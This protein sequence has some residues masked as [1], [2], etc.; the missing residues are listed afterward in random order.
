[1]KIFVSCRRWSSN[2]WWNRELTLQCKLKCYLNPW[3]T[4]WA[5]ALVK[6]IREPHEVKKKSF[7]LGG[8]RTERERTERESNRGRVTVDL[9]RRSWVRFPPRSKDFFF[10]SCGSLTPF[11][12]ANAQWVIHGFNKHYNLHFRVNSLFHHLYPKQGLEMEAAVLHRV[13]FLEYFFCPKL[14]QVS[15]PQRHP[16]TQTWEKYLP[17]NH[18]GTSWHRARSTTQL[19]E[20]N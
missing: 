13:A 1:M 2:Q 12:R 8:N 16:H 15:N 11:T 14:G 9:I 4:H 10:T 7:D 17:P 6:G 19:A 18:P 3:I 20:Q 5:L